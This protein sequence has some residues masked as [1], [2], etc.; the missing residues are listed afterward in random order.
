VKARLSISSDVLGE[1]HRKPL[2]KLACVL[3]VVGQRLTHCRDRVLGKKPQK[4]LGLNAGRIGQRTGLPGL[5]DLAGRRDP[6]RRRMVGGQTLDI[7]FRQIGHSPTHT[8]LAASDRGCTR[9][10]LDATL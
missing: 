6:C 2:R 8:I 1:D 7:L 5:R 3:E 10:P 9:R 4:L